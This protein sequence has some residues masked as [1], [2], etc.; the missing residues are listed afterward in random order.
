VT[1]H[2]RTPRAPPELLNQRTRAMITSL[3]TP[4][5]LAAARPRGPAP[6]ASRRTPIATSSQLGRAGAVAVAHSPPPI[7]S[8]ASLRARSSVAIVGTG[9]T[10]L[11][12]FVPLGGGSRGSRRRASTV[13][14]AAASLTDLL[15][16]ASPK[17]K[18]RPGRCCARD[19]IG[20]RLT[21]ET[22]VH[23]CVSITLRGGGEAAVRDGAHP[24]FSGLEDLLLLLLRCESDISRALG[25]GG[26][27]ERGQTAA[28]VSD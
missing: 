25:Q 13:P 6:A 27:R 10:S 22:R 15:N 2:N 18:V 7:A 21:H 5:S 12:A 23:T 20:C 11:L 26:E 19:V 3:A 14:R 1:R 17:G 4:G 8:S 24:L 9:G 28:R 16:P